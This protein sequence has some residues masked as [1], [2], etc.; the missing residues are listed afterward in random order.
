[1]VHAVDKASGTMRWT[2]DTRQDGEKVGFHGDPL[3]TENLII[4]GSDGSGADAVAHVYAIERATG[5]LRWKYRLARGVATDIVRDGERLYAVSLSDNIICL[6]VESGRLAWTFASG[7]SNEKQILAR[8]TPALS[9]G[10]V[11]FG[12]LDGLVYA[13]DAPSGRLLWKRDLGSPIWTPMLLL[14]GGLYAGTFDGRVHRLSEGSGEVLGQLD[15]GGLPFGPLT[16]ARDSIL[17]LVVSDDRGATLKAFDA[18]LRRVHWS[19]DPSAGKWTSGRPYLWEQ[20]VLAGGGHGELAAI[21]PT[22]GSVV[23]CSTLQGMIRAIGAGG[24]VLYVGTLEGTVYAY[25]PGRVTEA[26]HE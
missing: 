4:V 22:D 14:G 5:K 18:S 24:E 17:L 8:W 26:V 23:W 19:R 13:L 16:A 10:H 11:F 9:E 3:I 12:G 25:V 20:N 2:Y 21:S 6:D 15:V 7:S 1:V